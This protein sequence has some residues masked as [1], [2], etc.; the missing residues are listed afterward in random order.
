MCHGLGQKLV[1][2]EALVV[3]DV[4]KSIEKGAVL[5][6]RRGGK[7][8]AVYYKSLLRGMVKHFNQSDETPWKDLPEDF[9]YKLLHGTGGEEIELTFM[10]GGNMSKARRPFEG[11]IPNLERLYSESESEFTRNRLKSFMNPRFCDACN[12]QRLKPEILA[13]TLGNGADSAKFKPRQPSEKYPPAQNGANP[14]QAP[15]SSGTSI[16][17]QTPVPDAAR[18]YRLKDYPSWTCA[19]CPSNAR[20]TFFPD[21]S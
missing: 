10:R 18:P 21:Y 2:D 11:V 8:M 19:P 16:Q 3:P 7:R 4:E 12:G 17:P 6:W 9:K 14:L 20:P 1:F 15:P 5:P 13:V